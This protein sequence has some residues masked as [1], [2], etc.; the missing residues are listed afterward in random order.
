VKQKAGSYYDV[1]Y[2]L[3]CRIESEQD[4]STLETVIAY[5]DN[6]CKWIGFRTVEDYFEHYQKMLNQPFLL[7]GGIAG[8]I[9]GSVYEKHN[10]KTKDF[11]LFIE[12]SIFTDDTVMTIAV[13]NKLLQGNGSYI[14]EL[15]DFGRRFPR[16]G[17][18][19]DFKKWLFSD[20]PKPYGSYGNGSAMRVSPVGYAFNKIAD[21]WLEAEKSAEITHNHPDGIRGAVAIASAVY[22]ARKG[23]SKQEIKDYIEAKFNYNLSRTLDEIR[24]IYNFDISC[25]GSV[26][27]A[28]ISFL[29]STDFESSVR[30]AVSIG[31]DSDTVASISGA[32][33]EAFYKE[34]PENIKQ[35]VL[36]RLPD[37]LLKVLINFTSKYQ[38]KS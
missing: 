26:P 33:A 31:G 35:E 18:G 15:Q 36:K 28:I 30:N 2:Y 12:R 16:A 32:L 38:F 11:P 8:D 27:E 21:V 20:N 19:G 4:K 5:I 25:Q 1:P 37:D 22:L 23:S 24:P 6:D 10:I 17:Y 3:G 14:K 34:I 29:E 9:I 7:L 13:A